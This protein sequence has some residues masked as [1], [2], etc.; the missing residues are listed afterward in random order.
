MLFSPTFFNFTDHR[1]SHSFNGCCWLKNLTS[2]YLVLFSFY[3]FA[4][5]HLQNGRFFGFPR[6]SSATQK[7]VNC[8]EWRRNIKEHFQLHRHIRRGRSLQVLLHNHVYCLQT[9]SR[10]VIV[11]DWGDGHR[12]SRFKT[13]NFENQI[14]LSLF[15]ETLS[16]GAWPFCVKFVKL[17]TF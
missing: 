6:Q 4:G 16:K 13:D 12:L 1:L 9:Y 15:D 17:K 5:G 7:H 3:H 14:F 8:G 2:L 11:P 10:T